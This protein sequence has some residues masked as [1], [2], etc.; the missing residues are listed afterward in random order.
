MYK[1][2]PRAP[3]AA[4]TL[5]HG[6]P[7]RRTIS[8]FY[9]DSY[10]GVQEAVIAHPESRPFP[11]DISANFPLERRALF[12]WLNRECQTE[13]GDEHVRM[14]DA[15]YSD[16]DITVRMEEPTNESPID[17]AN[18]EVI[19]R[20]HSNHG[21][22][23][24]V[25]EA[26]WHALFEEI[27]LQRQ[28]GDFYM[29]NGLPVKL[30]FRTQ[31][32]YRVEIS[33]QTISFIDVTR[34]LLSVLEER[35]TPH[36]KNIRESLYRV[37]PFIRPGEI[38]PGNISHGQSNAL[39]T[40]ADF[41]NE[42]LKRPHAWSE[43]VSD[44]LLGTATILEA[45]AKETEFQDTLYS[46]GTTLKGDSKDR[47]E[48]F[49][50]CLCNI[51]LVKALGE[52]IGMDNIRYLFIHHPSALNHMLS[53]VRGFGASKFLAQLRYVNNTP[54]MRRLVPMLRTYPDVFVETVM[55]VPSYDILQHI[56]NGTI[57]INAALATHETNVSVFLYSHSS[58][59]AVRSLLE[60][61]GLTPSSCKVASMLPVTDLQRD[62][63]FPTFT[64]A[65]Q[66]SYSEYGA[67]P[68][69]G[70]VHTLPA[71]YLQITFRDGGRYPFKDIAKGVM[72]LPFE[73]YK[74]H[75]APEASAITKETTR[76]ALGIPAD[77]KVFVICSPDTKEAKECI[78]AY[79]K[80]YAH[81]PKINRPLLIVGASLEEDELLDHTRDK[82]FNTE[83]R[84]DTDTIQENTA[85][86]KPLADQD[87]I[88]LATRG[89]LGRFITIANLAVVGA[90]RNWQEPMQ[91]G[92]PTY[93]LSG[94]IYHN[95]FAQGVLKETQPTL[96]IDSPELAAKFL[97]T[98]ADKPHLLA[99]ADDVSS[100]LSRKSRELI[101]SMTRF[102]LLTAI[103]NRWAL[104]QISEEDDKDEKYPPIKENI[105]KPINVS[106]LFHEQAGFEQSD[107]Y[108]A[109]TNYVNH[110][111]VTDLEGMKKQIEDRVAIIA[112]LALNSTRPVHLDLKIW[113]VNGD[114]R[115]SAT[116]KYLLA[117]HALSIAKTYKDRF[118]S[119][120]LEEDYSE[121]LES[122]VVFEE[123]LAS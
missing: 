88:I 110:I 25:S 92:I 40:A 37:F 24:S 54:L 73:P 58:I 6:L 114:R 50:S 55:A 43:L 44:D 79:E 104:A 71:N 93:V 36:I 116:E 8:S 83:I 98:H 11:L 30:I 61:A 9:T 31:F 77:K 120:S 22:K 1:L 103:L 66:F 96:I 64:T 35:S 84:S 45:L 62:L 78:D 3:L 109:D 59:P 87:I 67:Q 10:G 107:Y 42:L 29:E 69:Q 39:K 105:F 23:L 97:S 94:K 17:L 102:M 13:I 14:D 95:H 112:E 85:N 41:L 4:S 19:G 21:I 81:T 111:Y 117:R 12:A 89:E 65:S 82:P 108:E 121:D 115:L 26:E 2:N 90:D 113:G 56:D 70:K 68:S 49:S 32:N 91:Q 38:Y 48:N 80:A 7:Q 46:A 76:T 122:S 53:K 60:A 106:D 5:P 57:D 99:A 28:S 118:S 123:R 15:Q 100:Q 75:E 47:L 74:Y 34:K 33:C 52:V 86:G 16:E 18:L 27:V 63:S 101:D 51:H 72:Y 119:M 20:R